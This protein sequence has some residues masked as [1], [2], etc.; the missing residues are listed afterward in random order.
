[1][2]LARAPSLEQPV[3]QLPCPARLTRL[4]QPP[5]LGRALLGQHLGRPRH[6]LCGVLIGLNA[7]PRHHLLQ[8]L[9]LLG[10]P[11]DAR[12]PQQKGV[13]GYCGRD[14][15]LLRPLHQRPLLVNAGASLQHDCEMMLVGVPAS[16]QPVKQLPRPVRLT[17]LQQPQKVHRAILAVHICRPGQSLG[18]TF[19]RL[20]AT[21]RHLPLKPFRLLTTSLDAQPPEQ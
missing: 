15:S 7:T 6:D 17:R 16:E 18:R 2:V 9:R 8:R 20:D 4:Q 13:G 12:A 11:L 10:A 5:Q 1:M 14:T 21:L 19:I 3:E